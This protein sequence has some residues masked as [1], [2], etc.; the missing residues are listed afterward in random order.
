MTYRARPVDPRVAELAV[1]IASESGLRACLEPVQQQLDQMRSELDALAPRVAEASE[2]VAKRR[3][4]GVLSTIGGLFGRSD[5]EHEAE[6]ARLTAE[7]AVL[8]ARIDAHATAERELQDQIAVTYHARMELA[9]LRDRAVAALREDP[10]ELGDQLRALDVEDARARTRDETIV[11]GLLLVEAARD[12]VLWIRASGAD[13]GAVRAAQLADEFAPLPIR[14]GPSAASIEEDHRRVRISDAIGEAAIRVQ[15]LLSGY[16]DTR[17]EWR[18]RLSPGE[19][20]EVFSG[21][22]NLETIGASPSIVKGATVLATLD[23]LERE[24]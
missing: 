4:G 2:M 11:R 19:L 16:E 23:D 5:E 6:A 1:R 24:L 20:R 3:A 12:A 8:Q 22:R 17:C 15:E 10:G 9:A 7:R 14:I 13:H 21:I 18:A